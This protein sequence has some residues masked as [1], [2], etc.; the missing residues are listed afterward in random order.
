MV[1]LLWTKMLKGRFQIHF[2]NDTFLSYIYYRM[3]LAI[4]AGQQ[5]LISKV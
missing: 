1:V 4:R 5:R 3:E 2:G